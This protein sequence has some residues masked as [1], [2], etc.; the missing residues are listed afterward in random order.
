MM[1]EVISHFTGSRSAGS[2]AAWWRSL[3]KADS[4]TI[5]SRAMLCSRRAKLEPS[6]LEF[7]AVAETLAHDLSTR[8]LVNFL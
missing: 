2:G 5:S 4:G 7:R 1:D 3:H 6:K 8:S